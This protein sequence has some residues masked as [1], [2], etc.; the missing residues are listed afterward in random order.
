MPVPPGERQTH[1]CAH[2][3]TLYLIPPRRC[4]T[5]P[6]RCLIPTRWCAP[7]RPIRRPAR[8]AGAAPPP[9]GCAPSNA[10]CA[11]RRRPFSR[12]TAWRTRPA[13][14]GRGHRPKPAPPKSPNKMPVARA[15]TAPVSCDPRAVQC[16]VH[17]APP[18]AAA[19]PC[20][21]CQLPPRPLRRP[22][23]VD[24]CLGGLFGC[25]FGEDDLGAPCGTPGMC[26]AAG[27]A[28]GETDRN[29]APQAQDTTEHDA[30]GMRI[31]VGKIM[32]S[33]VPQPPLLHK[34][35][36]RGQGNAI[37]LHNQQPAKAT[38]ASEHEKG[39]ECMQN[40]AYTAF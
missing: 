33:M 6:R 32:Q 24:L 26:G 29:V 25:N 15:T 34:V 30:A 3:S 16:A 18:P 10:V 37:V 7:A 21:R 40:A 36:L 19:A 14:R 12:A 20:R 4:L 28:R 23:A 9:V 8:G 2:P 22:H 38:G 5:P 11:R 17:C 31:S 35:Q 27:A 1:P 39:D 13:A